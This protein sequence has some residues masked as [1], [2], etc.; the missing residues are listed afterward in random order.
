MN[1]ERKG[2]RHIKHNFINGGRDFTDMRDILKSRMRK[3][4]GANEWVKGDYN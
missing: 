1:G 2:K 3:T 4:H